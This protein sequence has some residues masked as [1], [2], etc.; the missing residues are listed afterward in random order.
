VINPRTQ[1]AMI[2]E[3]YQAWQQSQAS[4]VECAL[5]FFV[6]YYLQKHPNKRLRSEYANRA[7]DHSI[8]RRYQYKKVKGKAID[9]LQAWCAGEWQFCLVD[10]I[11]SPREVLCYQARGIR[12]VT[13]LLQDY[14]HPVLNRED[15]F[16]FFVH[17]LEHGFMF[18]SDPQ[19]KEMQLRFF[20]R[21]LESLS[22]SL[23]RDYLVDPDFN[24]KFE[25]LIS[26]MNSHLE[27]YRFYLKSM[28]PL[29]E[30]HRFEFLFR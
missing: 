6:H 12:P 17:D 26:D 5:H 18:F 19:R 22:T 8:L 25:Y 24:A 14:L 27:H 30:F 10:E 23:W 29:G 7:F 13:I 1:S 15:C 3:V 28:I 4:D 16:E 2:H 21:V 9:S 20:K 11:L